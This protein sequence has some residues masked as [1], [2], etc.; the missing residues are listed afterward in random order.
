MRKDTIIIKKKNFIE[1]KIIKLGGSIKY[2]KKAPRNVIKK[3]FNNIQYYL[4][5]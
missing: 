1:K 5:S 4:F 3:G 2:K